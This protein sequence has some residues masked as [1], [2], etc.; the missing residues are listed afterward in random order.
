MSGL[1]TTLSPDG[2][3]D[4][5]LLIYGE[6]V[7]TGRAPTVAELA[8]SIGW[9]D[10][11]VRRGL[12]ALH[13]HRDVVLGPR[14]DIVMAHPFSTVPLGFSVMGDA[15]LWW[16]GCAWD[17]FAIPHL[18]E[19]DA[20]R[21]KRLSRGTSDG[22][23]PLV[24]ERSLTSS[25]PRIASGTTSSAV[26]PTNRSSAPRPASTGGWREQCIAVVTLWT[27]RLSGAWR[28]GGTPVACRTDTNDASQRPQRRTSP[29]SAC[30]DR[31]GDSTDNQDLSRLTGSEPEASTCRYS[32]A[33]ANMLEPEHQP[34]CARRCSEHTMR[35]PR[36]PDFSSQGGGSSFQD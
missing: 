15:T 14:H 6:L 36:R 19:L 25:R 34:D 8:S 11:Q 23:N 13:G 10:A 31:S 33:G 4:L 16:G 20:R 5:R 18:L 12:E 30:T 22:T 2:V 3:E 9:T 26:A 24:G 17:S 7:R 29:R 35:A 1:T 21:A 32:Q 28:A 27:S